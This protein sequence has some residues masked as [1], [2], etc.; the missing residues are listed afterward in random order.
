L[1][2][3]HSSEENDFLVKLSESGTKQT[4]TDGT[5]HV[6]IGLN[7][8]QTEGTYVWTDGTAKDYTNWG[9]GVTYK[10]PD[11]SNGGLEDCG[12]LWADQQDNIDVVYKGWNDLTCDLPMR[13]FICKKAA[14]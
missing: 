4:A 14:A 5:G 13:A 11:N 2:S 12:Q 10:Q 8:V 3:I 9:Q 1:T 6:W 7:D